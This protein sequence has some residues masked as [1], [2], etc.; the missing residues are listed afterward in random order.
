[1]LWQCAKCIADVSFIIW[2]DELAD[3]LHRHVLPSVMMFRHDK[4][5][6]LI[7]EYVS[8]SSKVPGVPNEG[9]KVTWISWS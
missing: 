9:I 8:D 1:M 7:M 4:V 2:G 3:A 5:L 6:L